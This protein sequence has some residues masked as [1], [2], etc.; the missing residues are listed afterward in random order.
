MEFQRF[1]ESQENQ[2]FEGMKTLL[3]SEPYFLRI[4]EDSVKNNQ[5]YLIC[6]GENTN[7]EHTFVKECNGLIC[8]KETNRVICYSYDKRPEF[9][10]IDPEIDSDSVYLEQSLEGVLMRVYHYGNKWVVST[11][12]CIDSN[13]ARWLSSRSFGDMFS[14]L[15]SEQEME[16]RLNKN[17]CYSFLL[18]HPDNTIVIKY[19]TPKIY[20][21]LT[22]DM[23][24]FEEV[25]EDVGIEKIQR[26]EIEEGKTWR[27]KLE[28]MKLIHDF[29]IEGYMVVDGMKHRQKVVS[30]QF[31]RAREL[32]GNTNDRFLRYLEIRKMGI[33]TIQEY[34]SFY[35]TTKKNFIEFEGRVMEFARYVL[36]TYLN[37]H[38][39]RLNEFQIPK[40]LCRLTYELHGDFL[41]NREQTD[42]NKVMEWISN[43]DAPL[44]LHLIHQFEDSLKTHDTS[45]SI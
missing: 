19:D 37:K 2:S 1:V 14:E 44:L 29:S 11:K 36:Q 5:L 7:L 32:W 39:N 27:E 45:S 9:E 12:R 40:Y 31:K 6:H 4:K 20:H 25:E 34:L 21:L 42:F 41:R 15:L 16:L 28:E 43:F 35:P 13:R 8:E 18:C 17:H 23:T 30:N 26:I 22:R 33:E 24:T 38:V 10:D 3:E